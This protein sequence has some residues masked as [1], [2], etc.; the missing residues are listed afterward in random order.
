[1]AEGARLDFGEVLDEL[2]RRVQ[3]RPYPMLGLGLLAGYVA[4]GGLFSPVSRPLA[5]AALGLLLV[6]RFR[7]RLRGA[8]ADLGGAQATVSA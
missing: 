3:E 7:E 2:G 8:A 5:R 6:S 1:M 4:G